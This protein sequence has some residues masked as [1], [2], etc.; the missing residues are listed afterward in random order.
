MRAVLPAPEERPI[1]ELAAFVAAA[2]DGLRV[3]SPDGAGWSDF[4]LL[5]SDGEPILLCEQWVGDDAREELDEL[6]EEVDDHDGSPEAIARVKEGLSGAGATIGLQIVMSAYDASV[7]AANLVI[8]FLEQQPG[9]LAQVDGVGWY[10]GG[11]QLLA[12]RS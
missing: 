3:A 11:E 8:D 10:A 9:V 7:A 12:L 5:G 2:G 4:D 6:A 1:E